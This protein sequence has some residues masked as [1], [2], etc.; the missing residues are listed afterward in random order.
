MDLN[1]VLCFYLPPWISNYF[2][3]QQLCM[4]LKRNK[5]YFFSFFNVLLKA[6]LLFLFS[7]VHSSCDNNKFLALLLGTHNFSHQL[8]RFLCEFQIHCE[9]IFFC[10][11]NHRIFFRMVRSC[12]IRLSVYSVEKIILASWLGKGTISQQLPNSSQI[13]NVFLPETRKVEP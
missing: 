1:N 12:E 2:W 13:S 4:V 11:C 9:N 6:T 5:F 10:C 7:S 3:L 8:M